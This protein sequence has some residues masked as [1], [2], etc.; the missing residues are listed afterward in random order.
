MKTKHLLM[1]YFLFIL[2]LAL[3]FVYPLLLSAICL[4]VD[5]ASI[6]Q[7]IFAIG[8]LIALSWIVAVV[9][10]FFERWRQRAVVYLLWWFF[11]FGLF[12]FRSIHMWKRFLLVFVSPCFIVG[13]LM[14]W[15]LFN[16]STAHDS[17][18]PAASTDYHTA[19]DLRR[20]TGVE[21]PEVIPVD[22]LFHD[23]VMMRSFVETRFVPCKPLTAE[24]FAK[25]DRACETDSECWKKRKDGYW[26][27]IY[28]T[29]PLDRTKGTYFRQVDR[30]DG[31]M[32]NDWDGDF[33][34]VFVPL[35]G[36]T[37]IVEDGWCR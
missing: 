12:F 31:E 11:P 37:I 26:Y 10:L 16:L 4:L 19:E 21:F 24:F 13:Y 6:E 17:I 25:L 15:L 32:V 9:G 29:R 20:A 18:S 27:E 22:S 34:Y 7:G 33:V 35:K 1:L 5:N 2:L 23:E 36:D 8:G 30:G 14:I 3:F 28:P